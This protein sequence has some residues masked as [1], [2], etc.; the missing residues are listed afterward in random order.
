MSIDL[1]TKRRAGILLLAWLALVPG[2]PITTN[3]MNTMPTYRR[4][5][6]VFTPG[7]KREHPRCVSFI[8]ALLLGIGPPSIFYITELRRHHKY[9]SLSEVFDMDIT[10]LSQHSRQ[11]AVT[12]VA[13]L[14]ELKGGSGS[15]SPVPIPV[16]G[17]TS[18]YRATTYDPDMDLRIHSSLTLSRETEY[19]QW[20]EISRESCETC[21]RSSG[22]GNEATT[23]T[24]DCNCVTTFDYVK[25][26]RPYR[27][28]SL[29]F[30]Q[31]AAHHNPQRDPMPSRRFLSDDA[32]VEFS[33][34]GEGGS[35]SN[36]V[37]SGSNGG[38][39][40]NDN[41]IIRAH[42]VTSMLQNGIRNA[43]K[44]TIKWV[45]N[46]IPPIPPFYAR[47]IPDRN[48]Y[49]DSNDL[50]SLK[51]TRSRTTRNH[52]YGNDNDS[53]IY[54]GDGYFFSP[55]RA[56]NTEKIFKHFMQYLEGT[57]LDWQIGDLMPSCEAGDI[58]FRYAVQ[59]P[60]DISILGQ[61]SPSTSLSSSADI[62]TDINIAI[63]PIKTSYSGQSR[64]SVADVGLVHEGMHSVQDMII[65]EDRDSF[66]RSLIFRL[67]VLLW[68]M[69]LT[70]RNYILS[71]IFHYS[72]S[73]KIRIPIP[74]KI[75]LTLCVWCG[76]V[77]LIWSVIWGVDLD[78]LMM[79]FASVLFG[80]FAHGF[81]PQP[82]SENASK[83]KHN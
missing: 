39:R 68:S 83:M 60:V 5:R 11:R 70:S 37:N 78:S 40:S 33:F 61:V 77:G 8:I 15:G 21:T 51:S 4:G 23:E 66:I 41:V 65:A 55:Y 7:E 32:T 50:L 26:W 35:S 74:T 45:K 34:G 13:A 10:E 62:D 46:G 80:L 57:L 14:R 9:M 42:L 43:R 71:K 48:R 47:W 16:H 56:S 18:T 22:S 36:G 53:F 58:R 75:A 30:D 64:G 27:I 67:I 73:V 25:S 79:G 72:E 29:L 49:E 6:R 81:P 44:R 2:N 24:Y 19:C 59:D 17:Q 69:W 1:Y 3:T 28:N 52:H 54:V 82:F 38:T 76:F 31:S 20:E 12:A 63:E